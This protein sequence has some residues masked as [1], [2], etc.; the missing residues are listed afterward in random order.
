MNLRPVRRG[1]HG[2]RQHGYTNSAP[3]SSRSHAS[4]ADASGTAGVERASRNR[5]HVVRQRAIRDRFK[6]LAYGNQPLRLLGG[7]VPLITFVTLAELT[8]SVEQRQWGASVGSAPPRA[9]RAG[10]SSEHPLL[11]PA[12]QGAV[13]ALGEVH[14]ADPLQRVGHQPVVMV[15]I[16]VEQPLVRGAAHQHHLAH[17]QVEVS[18]V[19]THYTG[20]RAQHPI[21]AP[22]HRRLARPVGT[23]QA[24]TMPVPSIV[25][26]TPAAC[27]LTARPAHRVHGSAAARWGAGQRGDDPD[28]QLLGAYPIRAN[29]SAQIRKI[30]PSSAATGR[31]LRCGRNRPATP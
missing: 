12:G 11:L 23:D 20:R 24:A 31:T 27:T 30:A 10:Q 28:G 7:R 4:T 18:I 9:T 22:Q 29:T 21:D 3:G 13:A 5:A 2:A 14:H 16:A 26:V 17:A 15:V 8:R 6:H 19:K 1:H 25:T